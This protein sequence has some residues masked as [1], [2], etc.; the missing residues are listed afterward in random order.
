MRKLTT[1]LLFA[2][3]LCWAVPALDDAAS[4]TGIWKCL[5]KSQDRPDQEGQLDLKQNGEEVTG[6]GSNAGGS[7]P[8]KGTFKDGKFKLQVITENVNWDLQ[9]TIEG[10]KLS[11]TWA[12]GNGLKGTLEGARKKD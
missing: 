6:T 11:G 5:L 8:I 2:A 7:A 12:I 10:D 3:C 4:I 1:V 9:G